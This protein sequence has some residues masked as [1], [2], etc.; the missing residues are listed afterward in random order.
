[1]R[2]RS[3]GFTLLEIAVALAI[4]GIGVVTVMQIFQGTLRLQGKAAEQNRVVLAARQKLDAL[5]AEPLDP[6]RPCGGH[7]AEGF[8]CEVR[9]ARPEDVGLTEEEWEELQ[10][11]EVDDG[12]LGDF[13]DDEPLL[14]V[15]E[16]K[17]PWQA[18]TDGRTFA[19]RT[20]RYYNPSLWSELD[21]AE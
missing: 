15:I 18:G 14:L 19:V 12:G 8:V 17:V 7:L 13:D 11:P 1:M 3:Q 6:D 10:L 9:P 4:L 5:F 21:F 16:L 2:R 20:L